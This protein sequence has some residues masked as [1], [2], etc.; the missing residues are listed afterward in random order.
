M[1]SVPP[2]N[3]HWLNSIENLWWDLKKAVAARK[4]S[5]SNELEAFAHEEWA[6]IPVERCKKLVSTY[7][8]CLLDVIK[9]KGGSTKY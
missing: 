6:K 3:D 9:A 7:R 1:I 4:P 5:N 8:K 2:Q